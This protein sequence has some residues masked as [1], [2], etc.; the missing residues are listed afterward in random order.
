MLVELE[1]EAPRV[2]KAG[3]A[4]NEP[5][6][7]VIHYQAANNLTDRWT[8]FLVVMHCAPGVPMLTFV[9]AEELERLR[10]RRHPAATQV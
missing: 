3:E 2:I 5:G 9:D 4:F 7:D 10:H 6:G 1:G 8:R